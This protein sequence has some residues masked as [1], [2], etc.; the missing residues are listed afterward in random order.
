MPLPS[1]PIDRPAQSRRQFLKLAC[2]GGVTVAWNRLPWAAA[3]A[4]PIKRPGKPYMKLSLAA[5][6]FDRQLDLDKNPTMTLEDF[7]HYCAEIDLDATELTSY[8]FPKNFGDDFLTRL[9]ELTFRLGLDISGTAIGNDFCY[10]AGPKRD[11][12]LALTR[13]WIDH[14]SFLGA[15]VIRI[16]GG[17]MR[18]AG[19]ADEETAMRRVADGINECLD[20]A[21]KKGV[22]LGIENHSGITES[23]EQI[24][25][26]MSMVKDSPWFGVNFDGG[27]FTGDDPYA[28]LARIAPYAVNVQ[29]KV[30]VT[31]GGRQTGKSE[32]ADLARVVR[33]LADAGYRGY[34]ALEGGGRGDDPKA[35][36]RRYIER[37]RQII[38]S[39]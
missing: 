15:P 20:H 37:L 12:Q 1:F 32:E 8:Y 23:P 36:I 35:S 6:S 2:A 25:K 11:E 27:G 10:P 16:F 5:Y 30:S 21:A 3:A 14:S 4:K 28:Q 7:I 17:Y 19:G 38:R 34:I 9:K 22:F 24:L 26:I 39:V 13:K 18:N 33:I 29:V 31:R